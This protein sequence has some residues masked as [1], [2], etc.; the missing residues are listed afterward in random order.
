MERFHYDGKEKR[1]FVFT[2]VDEQGVWKIDAGVNSMSRNIINKIASIPEK[3]S[4]QKMHLSFWESKPTPQFD[5]YSP[6]CSI[7]LN[8]LDETL[9]RAFD[10]NGEKFQQ[11]YPIREFIINGEKVYDLTNFDAGFENMIE[12]VIKP[13]LKKEDCPIAYEDLKG[14]PVSGAPAEK[15]SSYKD[16]EI[17]SHSE[18]MT[19]P[20][21]PV[22]GDPKTA[23]DTDA[24]DDLPF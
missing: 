3:I 7:R 4:A 21:A 14:E 2:F 6:Q 24:E 15:S 18:F 23:F 13:R 1:K 22:V 8:G 19:A 20:A 16:S 9:K 10:T 5:R 17:G 12:Q 11:K